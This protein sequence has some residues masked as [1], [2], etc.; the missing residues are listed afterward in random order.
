MC[1]NHIHPIIFFISLPLDPL[2]LIIPPSILYEYIPL[3][4]T[5][6]ACMSMGGEVYCSM[7]SFPVA[8]PLK[9]TTLPSLATVLTSVIHEVGW[10]AYPPNQCWKVNISILQEFEFQHCS[11]CT[12]KVPPL[13]WGTRGLQN[14]TNTPKPALPW[15]SVH[16][17]LKSWTHWAG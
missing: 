8:T 7:G 1:F 4:L 16:L 2:F 15:V 11:K 17:V 13:V 14:Q 9:K 12:S 5:K 6:V 10:L 3:S